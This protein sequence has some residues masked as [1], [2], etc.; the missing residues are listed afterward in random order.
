MESADCKLSAN[1][2]LRA[3][4]NTVSRG[5]IGIVAN[6]FAGTGKGEARVASLVSSLE[7]HGYEPVVARTIDER[8][9][10]L[11]GSRDDGAQRALV[12]IGGDGTVA[13]IVNEHVSCPIAVLPLGTENLFAAHFGF[14]AS[15]DQLV[16]AIERGAERSIDLGCANGRRFA[17]MAGF[18]FDADVVTRHHAS[19][20]GHTGEPRPTSRLAYVGPIIRSSLS[21][22]FPEISVTIDDGLEPAVLRGTTVVVFNLPRYALGLTVAPTA[23]DD[24]GK[25][26]VLVFRK[27]GPLHALRYLWL[28]F[29]NRHLSDPSVIHRTASRVVV[30]ANCS[31]PVQL[32]G[33][34]AG[35]LD[36]G[37]GNSWVVES[38]PKA[39]RVLLPAQTQ[40]Q[41]SKA[42]NAIQDGAVR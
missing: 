5:R 35:N 34:P 30:S 4:G 23:R 8:R 41:Q 22:R 9:S 16:H 10:L 15:V 37:D 25:L 1:R 11:S 3:P 36:A 18:G 31:V 20:L 24:D 39:L 14:K 38:L 2:G 33:D 21:Y 32:D 7:T 6:R 27:A 17:L 26:D 12:V 13:A 28:A 42:T 29:R 40:R 19:R